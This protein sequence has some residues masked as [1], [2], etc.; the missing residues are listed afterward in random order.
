MLFIGG[1][2]AG[3]IITFL[4]LKPTIEPEKQGG[5]AQNVGSDEGPARLAIMEKSASSLQAV[6][7]AEQARNMIFPIFDRARQEL[8]GSVFQRVIE[9]D[10]DYYGG[11]AG[12]AQTA[13]TLAITMP[14]GAKRDEYV[15][16]A[17]KSA[18]RALKLDPSQAWTQ[19]AMA[20]VEFANRNYNRALRL[21]NRAVELASDDGHVLDFHGAITLFS[22][23]FAEAL[24]VSNRDHLTLG[25]NRRF[26]NRNIRGAAS[27]HL[28]DF[29]TTVESFDAAAKMGDPLSA[30]SIAFTAVALAKTG[31]Q[32]EAREKIEELERSWPK[33]RIADMLYGIY[34]DRA[35]ADQV[36]V[37]LAELGWRQPD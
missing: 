3:V 8:I 13:A 24:K 25:A 10:P 30:P 5:S 18:Q 22:G 34:R 23:E 32:Q 33:A 31:R 28:G 26:A 17:T 1:V 29:K 4:A 20:W 19:S 27:L 7:L 14:P 37:P 16:L 35:H 21:S 2:G 11:Y 6:N 36:L 12:L 15:T 9:I